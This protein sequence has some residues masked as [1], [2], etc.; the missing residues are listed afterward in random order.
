[1]FKGSTG[2]TTGIDAVVFGF[3]LNG[4]NESQRRLDAAVVALPL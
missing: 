4:N 3:F 1:M 2:L